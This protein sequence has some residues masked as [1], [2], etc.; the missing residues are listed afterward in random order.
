MPVLARELS[1]FPEDLLD[2][3]R[4]VSPHR[5]WWVCH[6][7]SRQEKALARDL[8]ALAVPFYLPLIPKRSC[9]RGRG[10]TA[11]IPLFAGYVFVYASEEERIRA[12]KTN[13]VSRALYVE[14][15]GQLVGDLRQVARLIRCEA[16]LTPESR[17]TA[18][19]RVRVRGGVFAGIEGIV[20]RRR[21]NTRLL[22]RID[23][24]Q[25]GVSAEIS[26]FMIEPIQ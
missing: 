6:T 1:C 19:Q 10:A 2:S 25:R 17:V 21:D 26:D 22:V 14:D 9:I 16:P 8:L 24:L 7:K 11:H 20:L 3:A 12:L 18:G 4:I 13:R 23:F 5:R 15:V